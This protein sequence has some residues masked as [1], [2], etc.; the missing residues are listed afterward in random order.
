MLNIFVTH[1]H[2]RKLYRAL[3]TRVNDIGNNLMFE[4]SEEA[5]QPPKKRSQAVELLWKRSDWL[6]MK[7]TQEHKSLNPSLENATARCV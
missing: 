4:S 2:H 5:L 7:D 3:V 6:L 1:T